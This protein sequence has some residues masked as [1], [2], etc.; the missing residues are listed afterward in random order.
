[1]TLDAQPAVGSIAIADIDTATLGNFEAPVTE[2]RALLVHLLLADITAYAHVALGGVTWQQV[3]FSPSDIA[4]GRIQTVSTNDI[5]QG[6]ASS[7]ISDMNLRATV[8]GTGIQ[9]PVDTRLVGAAIKP[10]SP[11]LDGLVD[12]VTQLL[13]VHVGQADLRVDGVRCGKPTLVA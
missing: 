8:P 6:V 5:L 7:L 10:L 11:A 2:K 4:S 12:Q 9:V 1:M 3:T 13:G